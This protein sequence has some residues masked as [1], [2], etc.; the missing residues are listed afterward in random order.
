MFIPASQEG[1]HILPSD[2]ELSGAEV[3]LISGIGGQTR[4]ATK[5]YKSRI[6]YDYIIID[7]PPNLGMLTINALA[8]V[9]EV[10]V[11][12]SPTS[13]ALK[14]IHLL[15]R[16]IEDVRD[17]L[18]RPQLHISGVVC[19]R[20][21]RTNVSKDILKIV[22]T[23]FGDKMFTT[24]LRDS[25][26]MEEAESRSQSIF[27]YSARSNVAQDFADFVKEVISRE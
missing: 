16:T 17:N 9:D 25:I 8:A 1:L 20:Y 12:V 18:T 24:V 3:E 2:I 5:L 15:E 7:T 14:G 21:G 10:I 27:D 11:P 23:R 13:K 6:P 26:K 19:T 4:L 22:Q